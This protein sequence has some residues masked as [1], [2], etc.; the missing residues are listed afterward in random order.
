MKK[1]YGLKPILIEEIEVDNSEMYYYQYLPIK[2][3]DS[4]TFFIPPQLKRLEELIKKAVYDFTINLDKSLYLTNVYVTAKCQYVKKGDNLNRPGWHSDGFMTDDINYIWSDS[5]PTEYIEG[6]FNAIPQNHEESLEVFKILA[7]DREVKTCLPNVLYRL[8]EKVIH[9][10]AIN[11]QESFLRHFVKI[12]F[13][14][15]KYNLIGN[16]HNYEMNYDWEMKPRNK[17]RN[18]PTK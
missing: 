12:S 11:L 1:I 13:S 8:D 10:S 15:E 2:L 4:N 7:Y 5:L 9:R 17:E 18:H 6:N 3:S 16:S 14:R